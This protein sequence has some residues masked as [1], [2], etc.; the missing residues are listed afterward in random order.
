MFV[1]LV[2]GDDQ[3]DFMEKQKT[4]FLK[5]CGCYFDFGDTLT[6]ITE[7]FMIYLSILLCFL[8]VFIVSI[9]RGACRA[10]L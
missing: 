2:A 4:F 8:I 7:I 1:S 3:V 5:A 6:R 10:C 9:K